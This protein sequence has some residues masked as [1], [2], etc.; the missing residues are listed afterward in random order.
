MREK[1]LSKD[2]N[3]NNNNVFLVS[4]ETSGDQL[5][6]DLI[7]KIRKKQPNITFQGM[8][9]KKLAEVGMDI[10]VDSSNMDIVGFIEVIKHLGSIRHAMKTIKAALKKN[11]PDLLIL[12]DYPGFNLRIAKIAHKLGIKVL[13]YVSP[14][15]WA[16]KANRIKTIK[17][18]VTHIAVLFPFE[19][20]LYEQVNMSVSYAGHPLIDTVISTQTKAAMQKKLDI[21]AET[22]LVAILPGSRQLEI[23]RLLPT[24][25][26]ASNKLA[27]RFPRLKFIIVKAKH[28]EL[29]QIEIALAKTKI[30]YQIIDRDIYNHLQ[31]CDAAIVTSGTVTLE[32]ALLSIPMVII[33]KTSQLSYWIGKVLIKIKNVGLCNIVAQKRIVRELI[34]SDATKDNI[35]EEISHILDNKNYRDGIT[36]NLKHMKAKLESKTS[37]TP[38]ENTVFQLLNRGKT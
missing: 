12:I 30:N 32:I 15:V 11:R 21:S 10:L 26:Q 37:I 2:T 35:F 5:G 6:V 1:R 18:Y 7:K 27:K 23:Q 4:G 19:K 22:K 36:K 29:N 28:I 3:N 16:W 25:I 33:Y 34:Q 20:K 24:M 13:Y 31:I 14:Q 38:I 8:G 9:G 17:K